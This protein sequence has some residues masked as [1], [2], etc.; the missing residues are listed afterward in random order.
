MERPVPALTL[1]DI[2]AINRLQIET[3]GGDFLVESDN[4]INRGALALALDQLTAH[5]FGQRLHPTA[6]DQAAH[7]CHR[8]IDGHVFYDG[9]KRT[10][11]EV[12]R[13]YLEMFDIP[14]RIRT[15]G[16][17][18]D[19]VATALSIATGQMDESELKAWIYKR[20]DC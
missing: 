13:V 14:L 19:F 1:E 5:I 15:D 6:I 10:G 4:F 11:M 8:I 12:L 18:V 17:D 20:W 16:V 7:L 9:N 2:A 3:F